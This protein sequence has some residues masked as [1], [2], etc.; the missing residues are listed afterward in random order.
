MPVVV[1]ILR[2]SVLFL[3]VWETYKAYKPPRPSSRN[4][5]KPSARAMTQRKRNM[6]GC[7]AVWIV[8]CCFA[9]YEGTL[10]GIVG[11]FI[12]FYEEIK[13]LLLLFM[14]LTRARGAEPIYLHVIRP[15]LKPYAPLLDSM[16]EAAA[17]F[18]GLLIMLVSIPVQSVTS[19]WSRAESAT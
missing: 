6:K 14:L 9:L 7:L 17:L 11:I 13:A 8:W 18:G 1:P 3:N 16:L 5:G 10:D 19:W 15:L 2:L 4:N 12:P